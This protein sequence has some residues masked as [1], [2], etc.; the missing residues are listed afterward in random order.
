MRINKPKN[1]AVGEAN[2]KFMRTNSQD[3]AARDNLLREIDNRNIKS[4]EE[5][6]HYARKHGYLKTGQDVRVVKDVMRKAKLK[7]DYDFQKRKQKEQEETN[8]IMRQGAISNAT[9][10]EVAELFE[11]K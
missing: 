3:V 2:E 10:E 5:L 4:K 7:N 11:E 9:R 8:Q 1:K 6:E